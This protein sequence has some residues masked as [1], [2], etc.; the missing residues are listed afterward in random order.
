MTD[1]H[2][3]LQRRVLDYVTRIVDLE[4]EVVELK[5]RLVCTTCGVYG[6]GGTVDCSCLEPKREDR[7]RLPCERCGGSQELPC[8]DCGKEAGS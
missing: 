8:P 6:G 1:S 4:Q 5:E 2:A 7:C 3:E